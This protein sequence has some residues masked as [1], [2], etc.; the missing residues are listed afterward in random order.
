MVEWTLCLDLDVVVAP[1]DDVG[2]AHYH[3]LVAHGVGL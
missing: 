3:L 1:K 2:V